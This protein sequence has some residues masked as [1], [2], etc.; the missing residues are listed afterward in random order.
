MLGK[1]EH[2]DVQTGI[3]PG[4]WLFWPSTTTMLPSLLHCL[5][6]LGKCCWYAGVVVGVLVLEGPSPACIQ[7]SLCGGR[8]ISEV[9]PNLSIIHGGLESSCTVDSF[10]HVLS[11]GCL[12]LIHCHIRHVSLKSLNSKQHDGCRWSWFVHQFET[13]Q[14]PISV[15]ARHLERT[16][17]S[18]LTLVTS[19]VTSGTNHCCSGFLLPRDHEVEG[20]LSTLR[21]G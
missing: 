3:Y 11:S 13:F 17:M 2:S 21:L 12:V 14:G 8:K 19:L 16:R 1:R 18:L 7:N 6:A 15:A 10:T 4:H 20:G 5:D 9:Y